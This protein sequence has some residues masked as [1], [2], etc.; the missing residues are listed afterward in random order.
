MAARQFA[1]ICNMNVSAWSTAVAEHAPSISIGLATALFESALLSPTQLQ[2]PASRSEGG[3]IKITAA[4]T[5]SGTRATDRHFKR[6]GR[7]ALRPT[8][9]P[10]SPFLPDTLPCPMANNC[11]K[12]RSTRVRKFRLAPS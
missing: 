10:P 2:S 1:A 12:R 7:R 6:S 4:A 3:T 11:W 5:A 8:S 9:P